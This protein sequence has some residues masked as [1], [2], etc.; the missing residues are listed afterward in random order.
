MYEVAP[1]VFLL[2]GTPNYLVN[3]YLVCDVL[4]DAGT[5]MAQRGLLRQ[6]KGKRISKHVLTHVHP[7][8]QG[9]SK[10][11]CEGFSIPLLCG[12][13]DAPAM[14]SGDMRGQIPRNLITQTQ[15]IFW[16]GPAHP[17]ERTLHEGDL[18]AGFTVIE[19]PGHSPGHLAYWRESDRTLILGDVAANIDFLTLKT[20]LG[21][22]PTIFTQDIPQNRAS[23]RKLA[24][25]HPQTILFGHGQ[26]LY[27]GGRFVDWAYSLPAA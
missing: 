7:D 21:E 19:T 6:L 20:R 11:I 1:N 8:H 18:V 25:L 26:P 15:D 5:K 12:E 3:V 4:I 9:A 22:P 16:T 13:S 24:D 23:A 14:E 17:V 10:S 27:D 2:N